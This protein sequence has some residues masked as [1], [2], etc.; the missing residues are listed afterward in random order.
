[1]GNSL[2]FVPFQQWKD[3]P[4]MELWC[5]RSGVFSR[6]VRTSCEDERVSSTSAVYGIDAGFA[7]ISSDVSTSHT[8]IHFPSWMWHVVHP[9]RIDQLCRFYHSIRIRCDSALLKL[10]TPPPSNSPLLSVFSGLDETYRVPEITMA[11]ERTTAFSAWAYSFQSLG[12]C[13]GWK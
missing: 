1:M 5:W 6:V 8:C 11:S 3:C 13:L 9:Q 10:A 12:G 7:R 4:H 2:Q